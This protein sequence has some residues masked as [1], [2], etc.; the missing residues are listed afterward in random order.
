[1]LRN[2]PFPKDLSMNIV[3]MICEFQWHYHKDTFITEIVT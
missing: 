1:M 3:L 2:L